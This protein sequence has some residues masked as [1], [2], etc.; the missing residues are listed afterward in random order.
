M[1][2]VRKNCFYA[3]AK[4]F[5]SLRLRLAFLLAGLF[6]WVNP[7]LADVLNWNY[8]AANTDITSSSSTTTVNGVSIT[9]SGAATA[10][11]FT[12]NSIAIQPA[13]SSNGSSI[14]VI[15]MAMDA[16]I[17]DETAFQTTTVR[18]SEPVY[19][20]SFTLLD[21]DGGPTF[22]SIWNDIVDFN[23]DNG[24]PSAVLANGTWVTYNSGTGRATAISNQNAA[25]GNANQSFGNITVTF[26]GPI[27][28]FTVRHYAAAVDNTST[29]P[30]ETD[31]A[32]QVIYIDDVTF[33][34]SARLAVEKTSTGGTGT[35]NFDISNGMI[36]TAP[37]T[38][39]YGTTSTS[40]T[41]TASG[42]PVTGPFNILGIVNTLTTV[43]ET[44]PS[45]W[46][47]T[48]ASATCT[49]SNSA[50]S[51]NPASFSASISG[52][53]ITIAATNVKAGAVITCAVS[54]MLVPRL[55]LVK[56]VTNNN[57][58]TATTSAFTLSAAGPT[59]I[60]GISG[61]ANVTNA[62]VPSGTY[63]LSET[64]LAGY[65][66]SSWSCTAGS[67][68][69]SNLTLT[70]GQTATCTINNN[71][72]GPFLTLVKTVTND[73]GGTATTSSFTLTATGPVTISGT[74]GSVAVTNAVVNAGTYALTETGPAGYAAGS[75]SCAGGSQS[76]SNITAALG[77]NITC[78]IN[79]NDIAPRLTLVKTVTDT[80]G[81]ASTV[82][83]FTL[84][85]TGPV[86]ISGIT[87]AG[88]VTN[89][90][91]NAGSYVLSESGPAGYTAGSWSCTAGSLSGSTLSLALAQTATCTINN[92][93][94]PTLTIA[95]VS[96]GAT[97]SFDFTGTNGVPNQTITTSTVGVA[98]NG[99]AATLT[100]AGSATNVSETPGATWMLTSANCTGM[101]TGGTATLSGNTLSLNAAATAAGR[102]IT[103]TFTNAKLIPSLSIVKVANTGGP[104][105]AGNVVGYTYTV[106][107][108][109]NVT[110]N[111][112]SIADVHGGFGTDP[113]PGSEALVTDNGT[114]GDST[115]SATNGIWNVLAPGDVIRFTSSYTVVQADIDNLQ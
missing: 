84:V 25:T 26:A 112:V 29:G 60:S 81:G 41:T 16:N 107:N 62:S 17:D 30:N 32:N 93:R 91:I 54:N 31:P 33:T 113:T 70:A 24:H 97:G 88:T 21:I 46:E 96:T 9:T 108:T 94:L 34:R 53:V 57:G 48:G 77:Q 40:V 64:A 6:C 67:L 69:G 76:G 74:S 75:W 2:V 27:T 92:I 109:G 23:S 111:N 11:K 10:G 36:F 58:G 65:T 71:D 100:A 90:A 104:V 83:S 72:T 59:T 87:G 95:K 47:I 63:A 98:V 1:L 80:S 18:F 5:I 35:F 105:N 114:T 7:S 101:G 78:T 39:V 50:A 44:G 49:D 102:S 85:A 37:S 4:Y 86:T 73:N 61:S 51:G 43:T 99:S 110:I 19:N 52:Q 12:T 15:Q 89:A 55:T 68:S 66:A 8:P 20:V 115:D 103:C 42:V 82:P 13:V 38:Y 45:G 79:N 14:G 56:T 28:F 106:T 3:L 22:T